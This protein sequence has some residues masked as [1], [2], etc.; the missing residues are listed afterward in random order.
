MIIPLVEGTPVIEDLE[1][2]LESLK[3]LFLKFTYVYYFN[4][5]FF[6]IFDTKL[7]IDRSYKV[8]KKE[9]FIIA[10]INLYLDIINLF[11]CMIQCLSFQIKIN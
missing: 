7:I 2:L 6:I 9:D 3:I 11:M 4:W 10:S 1:S 8:Y 5:F